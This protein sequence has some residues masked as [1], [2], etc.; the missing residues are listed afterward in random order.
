MTQLRRIAQ[1]ISN[2]ECKRWKCRKYV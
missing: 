1:L 2:K